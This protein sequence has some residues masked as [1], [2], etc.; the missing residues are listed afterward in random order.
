M[1]Q[2]EK[3]ILTFFGSIAGFI[4]VMSLVVSSNMENKKLLELQQECQKAEHTWNSHYETCM[5]GN[6][7][8]NFPYGSGP[9]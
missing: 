2:T 4:I 3:E 7:P 1:G 6:L 5:I 8:D 9:R